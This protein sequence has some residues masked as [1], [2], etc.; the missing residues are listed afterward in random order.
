MT[1]HDS[2]LDLLNNFVKILFNILH[3]SK[4][5]LCLPKKKTPL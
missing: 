3:T 2:E 1:L 5:Q 4:T